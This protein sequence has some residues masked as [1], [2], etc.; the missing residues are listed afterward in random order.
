MINESKVTVHPLTL[1]KRNGENLLRLVNQILNLTK[2]ESPDLKINY[3]QG[4]VLVYLRYISESLHSLANA[5]NVMLRLSSDRGQIVMDYDPERLLQIVHN[6]L[7]NAIKFTPSGGKVNM[8]AMVAE[9]ALVI[10]VT[11]TGIGIPADDL[12][13]IF[14]RFFQ[15]KLQESMPGDSSRRLAMRTGG[16]GIGLSL[17]RELVQA[18]GGEISAANPAPGENSGTVFTVK[19]PV[20]NHAVMSGGESYALP[21]PDTPGSNHKSH[22][23]PESDF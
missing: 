7:S 16:S 6:L 21:S 20:S 23:N 12:P 4:D 17:T 2:L 10:T 22:S 14:D 18:M 13:Y 1:V 8:L 15:A 11:D 9:K 5:R 19:L 3:V